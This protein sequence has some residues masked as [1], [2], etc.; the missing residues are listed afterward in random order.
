VAKG[1]VEVLTLETQ[2]AVAVRVVV[3]MGELDLEA[4]FPS[5]MGRLFGHLGE[6]GVTPAG[7][8]YARYA[9][10]GPER[11]DVELGIPLAAPPAGLKALEPDDQLGAT[12]LPGGEAA[13]YRH[14]GPYPELG[15][16]YQALEAWLREAGRSPAGPPWESYEVGPERVGGDADR[17]ETVVIWPLA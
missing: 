16:A 9:E 1:N 4:M 6:H 5:A 12:E 8:P 10:F 3:P 14:V 7:P 15:T 13:A 17:L 2:P 11:A